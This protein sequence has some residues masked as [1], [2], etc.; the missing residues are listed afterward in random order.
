MMV[1]G[2]LR[3]YDQPTNFSTRTGYVMDVASPDDVVILK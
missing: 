3:A 1:T 2:V